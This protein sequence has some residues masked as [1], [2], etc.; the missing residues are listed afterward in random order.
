MTLL[1][2]Y[3]LHQ[4]DQNITFVKIINFSLY[5]SIGPFLPKTLILHYTYNFIQF[6]SYAHTHNNILMETFVPKISCFE[7]FRKPA[8][9]WKVFVLGSSCNVS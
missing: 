5:L 4:I 1:K 2:S 6:I 9:K 8:G 3:K 7:N